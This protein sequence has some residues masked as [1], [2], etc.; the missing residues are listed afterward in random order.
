MDN[1]NCKYEEKLD[2]NTSEWRT[3]TNFMTP[4][5]FLLSQARRFIFILELDLVS[6]FTIMGVNNGGGGLKAFAIEGG[7]KL[8]I[9]FPCKSLTTLKVELNALDHLVLFNSSYFTS[10][11]PSNALQCLAL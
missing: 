5:T 6:Q 1:N 4:S 8:K 7:H 10:I 9:T 3:F 11:T 2:N